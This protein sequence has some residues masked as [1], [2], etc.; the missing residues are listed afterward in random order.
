[1]PI[2]KMEWFLLLLLI[3]STPFVHGQQAKYVQQT[4]FLINPWTIGGG[5]YT[6]SMSC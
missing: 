2:L 1:M 5:F 3:A 6:N 4:V